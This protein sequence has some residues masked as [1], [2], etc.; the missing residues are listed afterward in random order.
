MVCSQYNYISIKIL[1][2]ITIYS[3]ELIE[4]YLEKNPDNGPP[5][6][7]E[8]KKKKVRIS[9]PEAE[10]KTRQTLKRT[11]AERKSV[12]SDDSDDDGGK[13]N[14]DDDYDE[15]A[16]KKS[17]PKKKKAKKSKEP[18]YEVSKIVDD[19]MKGKIKMYRIRWVGY[20]AKGKQK[21]QLFFFYSSLSFST[22]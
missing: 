2:I 6:E 21:L 8:R 13:K 3:P 7:K 12:A 10:T 22:K 11:A 1:N 4:R 18:V 15:K 5:A 16:A 19:K 20:G 17:T 14:E 9:L